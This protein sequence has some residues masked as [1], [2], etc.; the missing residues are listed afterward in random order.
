MASTPKQIMAQIDAFYREIGETGQDSNLTVHDLPYVM[1]VMARWEAI[2]D[3]TALLTFSLK[4]QH[5]AAAIEY[6]DAL[7]ASMAK[8]STLHT[9]ATYEERRAVWETEHMGEL[10]QAE[11]FE[12]IVQSLRDLSEYL[13]SKLYWL[14]GVLIHARELDKRAFYQS[15]NDVFSEG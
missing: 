10:R 14:N 15:S 12:F 5:Q 1:A 13:R 6:G 4:K 8:V 3:E 2:R 7:R 9:K 11:A